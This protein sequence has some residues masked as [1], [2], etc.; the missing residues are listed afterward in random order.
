MMCVACAAA[1][2]EVTCTA[3]FVGG[4]D[5]VVGVRYWEALVQSSACSP[6]R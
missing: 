5:G 1:G 4:G 6:I 2:R 3:V